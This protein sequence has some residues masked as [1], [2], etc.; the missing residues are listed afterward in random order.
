MTEGPI[1]AHPGCNR[2]ID[3]RSLSGVCRQHNHG[4]G[5]RCAKCKLK[6]ERS[7][8]ALPPLAA[9]RVPRQ[10]RPGTHVVTVPGRAGFSGETT[11]AQ[12]ITLPRP[13]WL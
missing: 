13:P 7:E 8:P 2:G 6:P 9:R 3:P 5:C 11:R 4:P 10:G 1:C 12:E